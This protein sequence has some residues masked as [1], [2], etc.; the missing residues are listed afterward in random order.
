[1]RNVVIDADT[2]RLGD[3]NSTIIMNATSNHRGGW[4]WYSSL[5]MRSGKGWT[6]KSA[7]AALRAGAKQL[8]LNIIED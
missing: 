2:L 7:E 8:D 1:M 6:F 5:A 3:S 4:R